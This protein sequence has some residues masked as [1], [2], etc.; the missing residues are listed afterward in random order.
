MPSYIT[1][2]AVVVPAQVSVQQLSAGQEPSEK[3][4][5]APED[6]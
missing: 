6:A 4:P 3:H 1:P 5:A 2:A